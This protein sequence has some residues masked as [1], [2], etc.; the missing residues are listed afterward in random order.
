MKLITFAH[1]PEAEA[2]FNHFK[3]TSSEIQSLFI[4]SDHYL[5]LT[6]EGIMEA[7]TLVSFVIGKHSE[8]SEI[9]NFGVAGSLREIGMDQV[10]ELRHAYYFSGDK[11]EFKS[12]PV[13]LGRVDI[14]SS[15]E[16]VLSIIKK[17]Q[18]R[19]IADIVDREIWGIGYAGKLARKPVRCFKYV[20]DQADDEE[21]C[22][23]VKE[24]VSVA[25]DAL[26]KKFLLLEKINL[27]S[28]ENYVTMEEIYLTSS[29]RREMDKLLSRIEIKLKINRSDVLINLTAALQKNENGNSKNKAKLL[30][31]ELRR[32][33]DPEIN[34]IQKKMEQLSQPYLT[35][36]VHIQFDRQLESEEVSFQFK[37]SE[38]KFEEKVNLLKQFPWGEFKK[39]MRGDF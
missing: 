9:F 22:K 11:V 2:F 25:S 31:E 36:G 34:R 10:I 26:L 14:V 23:V 32:I 39:I 17:N 18:L 24:K 33:A 28:K 16:R 19:P 38:E 4:S 21:I 20:S 3:Y 5:L 6:G 27:N 30:L 7:A 37:S 12:Y 1:R 35:E 15:D 13:G 29:M 8:I